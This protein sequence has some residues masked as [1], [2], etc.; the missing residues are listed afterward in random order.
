MARGTLVIPPLLLYA[1]CAK[2]VN[3]KIAGM[4]ASGQG[5]QGHGNR[6]SVAI[7]VYCLALAKKL[8]VTG[9]TAMGTDP[10]GENREGPWWHGASRTRHEGRST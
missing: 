2:H 4:H 10:K 8:K 9:M 7:C 1:I 6:E 5:V 3:M